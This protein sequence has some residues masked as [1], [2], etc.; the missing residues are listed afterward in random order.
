MAEILAHTFVNPHVDSGDATITASSEWNDGHTFAGG[1]D[2]QILIRD[3]TQPKGAR[4]THGP[5]VSFATSSGSGGVVTAEGAQNVIV[6]TSPAVI[7]LSIAA[8]ALLSDSTAVKMSLRRDGIEVFNA[9][10]V[11]SDSLFHILPTFNI[12]ESAGTHTYGIVLSSVNGFGTFTGW[13]SRLST[14][15]VGI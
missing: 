9:N 13:T 12:T 3:S 15:S 6:F 5:R 4:W 14:F 8:S 2:G 11:G 7:V 1:A 10:F